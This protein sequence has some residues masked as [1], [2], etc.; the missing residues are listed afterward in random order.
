MCR[1]AS[2]GLHRWR[3]IIPLR[4]FIRGVLQH[5]GDQTDHV[6]R[7]HGEVGGSCSTEVVETHGLSELLES[8]RAD[9]VVDASGAERASPIRRPKPVMLL[10]ATEQPGADLFQIAQEIGEEL[11]LRYPEAF[12]TLRLGVLRIEKHVRP[13]ASNSTCLLRVRAA[14]LR[15]RISQR[16]SRAMIRPSRY[17]SS[18]CLWPLL[19]GRAI[20]SSIS[21]MPRSKVCQGG[22]SRS[23]RSSGCA[24]A[25]ARRPLTETSQRQSVVGAIRRAA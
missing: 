19:G 9:N 5:A 23:K 24:R 6:G 20:A 16:V 25:A 3:K 17:W 11:I 7:V 15:R 12:G 13:T 4:D 8:S 22:T 21:S 10:A 14:M 1:M 2:P 18:R